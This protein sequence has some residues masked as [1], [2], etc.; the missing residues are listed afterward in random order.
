MWQLTWQK[1]TPK[2]LF[3]ERKKKT[4]TTETEKKRRTFD[5]EKSFAL[6]SIPLGVRFFFFGVNKSKVMIEKKG[7]NKKP[8]NYIVHVQLFMNNNAITIRLYFG[9]IHF[10]YWTNVS[11]PKKQSDLLLLLLLYEST[12]I[13]LYFFLFCACGNAFGIYSSNCMPKTLANFN[14]KPELLIFFISSI[15]LGRGAV[16]H[17]HFKSDSKKTQLAFSCECISKKNDVLVWQQTPKISAIQ[18]VCVCARF[19]SFLFVSIRV[20]QL[21]KASN[22]SQKYNKNTTIS[23]DMRK[24]S[25]AFRFRKQNVHTTSADQRH[26]HSV[27]SISFSCFGGCQNAFNSQYFRA[28][29]WENNSNTLS[30]WTKHSTV[31]TIWVAVDYSQIEPCVR[32]LNVERIRVFNSLWCDFR[33]ISVSFKCSMQCKNWKCFELLTIFFSLAFNKF[34][35]QINQRK[36]SPSF[37]CLQLRWNFRPFSLG[38]LIDFAQQLISAMFNANHTTKNVTQRASAQRFQEKRN[39]S[40]E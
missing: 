32:Y 7:T 18:R 37:C 26:S 39:V 38:F 24:S 30:A 22:T 11:R 33:F 9:G 12:E 8:A 23:C 6:K 31:L 17:E 3:T 36:S 19:L 21:K 1:K 40:S 14:R 15:W 34:T 29:D 10:S 4:K 20:P 27:R 28:N 13:H 16:R 2:V 5:L 35:H 25:L